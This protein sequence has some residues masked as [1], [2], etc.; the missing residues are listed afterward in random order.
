[1]TILGDLTESIM[2]GDESKVK[3]IVEE[4]VK[5]K[6]P[7]KEI[8]N[9]GLIGVMNIVGVKFKN[10]ELFVPEVLMAAK[11][12]KV[13][14]GVL[15]PLLDKSDTQPIGKVVIGT[16]KGDLHDIGKNLVAMM[17]EGSGFEV[18]DVG[19]DVPPEKF[20][21]A[22]KINKADLCMMS[23]LLTTTMPAMKQTIDAL[24]EAGL[25]GKVK[26]MIGGAPVTRNFANSI[27]ADGYGSNAAAAV[28][29][30]KSLLVK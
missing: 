7:V 4:A 8:L 22:M 21:E 1:M 18:I 11:A 25:A 28:D 6:V 27:G 2:E 14:I 15:K 16:V 26:T 20:V 12:M 19:V 13:G 29:V 24:K 23:A 17:V 5:N 30:A 10:C 3:K 9:D